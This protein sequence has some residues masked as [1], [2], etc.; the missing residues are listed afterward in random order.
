MHVILNL[1]TAALEKGKKIGEMNFNTILTQDYP[2][3]H[4]NM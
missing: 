4:F 3:Y 2:K 1:L